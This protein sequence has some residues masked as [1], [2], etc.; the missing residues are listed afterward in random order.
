MNM[1]HLFPTILIAIYLGAGTVYGIYGDWWRVLY[2][3]AA[4]AITVAVTMMGKT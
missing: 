4:A 2:W 1:T 3:A